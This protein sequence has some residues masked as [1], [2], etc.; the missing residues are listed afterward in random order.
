MRRWT[1]G[2]LA[3]LV[4]LTFSAPAFAQGGGASSTGTIQGRVTDAQGAVLPGVAV[5]ATSPSALGAQTTV[6]SE[7]G[8]YRFPALP[9]GAYALT[10][11]LAGFNTLKREGILIS[12]GFTANVNVELSLATLQETVT[13]SGESPVIDTSA[14][15]VVQTFKLDQLQSL[16]NGR[17]FWSLLAVTPG[18]AMGRID[19]GGNRAGTQTPY[20]AYGFAGQVRVLIEGI[21]T[22]EGTGAA[23]FYFDYSSVEEVFLGTLGQSAE[24]PNPGV[25]SQFITKSG[26]NQFNGE[27]YL[28]WYNNSL[29]ASNIPEAV[30]ARGI[31]RGSNEIDRYYDT[32]INAGGPIK[33]DKLWWFGTYRTQFNAVAQPQFDFD[34]TFDT[35]LWNPVVKG[36]YQMNQKNKFIG[37]YQ[38]GTKEQPNRLIFG[39][40]KY[41]DAGTTLAQKSSSW[42]YKAEWNGTINDKVYL[43]GRFGDFGYYFPLIA[44]GDSQ[45]WFRDTGLQTLTGSERRWQLD[46]DRKQLNGAASI[47]I[48]T[49]KGS[50]TLKVGGEAL[51]EQSWEGFQQRYGGNIE[52]LYANGIPSQVIFG[53]PTAK[54]VGGMKDNDNGNL[55]SRAALNHDGF[56]VNDTWSVGRV[57]ASGGV[58]FDRYHGWLPEQEQLAATVGPVSVPAEIFPEVHFFTWNLFAPRVG[59]TYDLSGDGKTV[60]KGNYGFYWHNPGVGVASLANP[61]TTAKAGTYSWNDANGDRRWQPGEQGATPQS[62]VLKGAVSL[63]PNIESPSTHE[64]S[65]FLERQVGELIGIRAGFV[66]K[67]EENLLSS[68]HPVVGTYQPGRPLSAYSVPFPFTDIGPDGVAGSSDDRTVT[69]LG[70]PTSQ[71]GNFSTNAV[72][73]NLPDAYGRFKTV[74][75]SVSRRYGNRWSGQIGFG[76]T[77]TTDF[78][79]GFPQNPNQAGVYDRT[80]WGLKATG[81]YDAPFGIRL[82]PVLR[83]QSG[84]NFA[85]QISVPGNAATPFGL[86]LPATTYYAED[87]DARREDNIWVFDVRADKTLNLSDRMRIR[88]FIDFFNITNSHASEAI[89]RTTGTTFLRPANILA[90]FTTR[91]GFRFI[92]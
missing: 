16:P 31:R 17:D 15:R 83:H 5:T 24:M 28:D 35:K 8:N 20:T 80:G 42:V 82:S 52:H 38:W 86:T 25:Q 69:L 32:A 84:V 49:A 37:Y 7:T 56:F 81:S 65:L 27:Y 2:L 29:Q 13:V 46:R 62:L 70:M 72:V 48:D 68:T 39:T 50:H 19:V 43:E 63:D 91:L 57:T 45:Y 10:F 59:F 54:Q 3:L 73:M 90:P 55:T 22:T 21:N 58:R 64:A 40:Y 26:G 60:L 89:T 6:T 47:F 33:K 75:A 51:R 9:P 88:A 61:N 87:A 67:N 76:Y 18:V 12:L 92:W 23:G 41:P 53:L 85:R 4:A 11:E 36:T 71:A 34:Q 74:E 30:I 79:E 66:Y 77:W 1:T 14:T 78:P 44:N